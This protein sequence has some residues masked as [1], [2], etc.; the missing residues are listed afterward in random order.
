MYIYSDSEEQLPSSYVL[1][2]F[3]SARPKQEYTR[4][5]ITLVVSIVTTCLT[6]KLYYKGPQRNPWAGRA[7]PYAA[8]HSMYAT[9]RM[10]LTP[11]YA[12]AGTDEPC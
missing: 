9:I 8:V 4:F 3:D 7:P 11:P 1:S 6:K 12:R 2:T 10:Q 5:K